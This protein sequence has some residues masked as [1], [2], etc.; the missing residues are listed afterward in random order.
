MDTRQDKI[1]AEIDSLVTTLNRNADEQLREQV[2]SYA[3]RVFSSVPARPTN[4]TPA[5]LKERITNKVSQVGDQRAVLACQDAAQRFLG[6]S[7]VFRKQEVLRMLLKLADL[8]Q[9]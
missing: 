6:T 5:E 9:Q 7:A 1:V 8:N 3:R 2:Q 4:D